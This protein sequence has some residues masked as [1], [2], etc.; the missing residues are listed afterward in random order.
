[1]TDDRRPTQ[2]EKASLFRS[3]H[4]GGEPFVIPNPFDA[5]S[6]RI[7][8][9]MGF[10]ALATTSGGF[11]G[12]FGLRDGSVTRDDAIE[13]SRTLV[14]A[15]DLPVSADLENGFGHPPEAVAETVRLAAGAGLAGCSV[16]DY[17]NDP[18]N[19]LYDIDAAVARVAAGVEAARSLD[20]DFVLTARAEGYLR[21]DPDP[22]HVTE[23][24]QA[25]EAAGADVLMAPG[26]PELA[27]IE[28]VCSSVG[29]PFN[30]TVGLP[31]PVF[32]V[33][34]LVSAGVHRIS[35]GSSLWRAAMGGLM[36]AAGE[37]RDAGTF[38]YLE[39]AAKTPELAGWLREARS[40]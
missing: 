32:S 13:H 37:A 20:R 12:T 21:G 36:A 22:G 3:L 23:R 16:E 14:D 18:D 17:T 9:G 38:T 30:F 27:T 15:V 7:L 24:L 31:G 10:K 11:A 6:A 35:L 40:R 33:A 1:M 5:G 26:I 25:F 28:R 4:E 19:P 2:A 39:R 29:R 8:A 34:E